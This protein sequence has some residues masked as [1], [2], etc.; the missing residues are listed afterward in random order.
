MK[1]WK[2]NKVGFQEN[3]WHGDYKRA[4]RT[5]EHQKHSGSW[6][7]LPRAHIHKATHVINCQKHDE[8]SFFFFKEIFKYKVIASIWLGYLFSTI[9]KK[10]R[11]L[12]SIFR[13]TW[14]H[15]MFSF[16]FSS[17]LFLKL[18]RYNENNLRKK[19]IQLSPSK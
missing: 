6:S 16:L 5:G 18:T 13:S 8:G 1:E 4:T 10:E 19:K 17:F 3:L 14:Y 11:E 9:P 2:G 15:C 12:W 7:V